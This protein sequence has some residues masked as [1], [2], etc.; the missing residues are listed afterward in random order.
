MPY[1]RHLCQNPLWW[2]HAYYEDI[3][4]ENRDGIVVSQI[5]APT[6]DEHPYSYLLHQFL[7]YFQRI[8]EDLS[9]MDIFRDPRVLSCSAQSLWNFDF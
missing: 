1:I 7:D 3:C 8:Y 6:C 5:L 4:H 2:Y 9:E